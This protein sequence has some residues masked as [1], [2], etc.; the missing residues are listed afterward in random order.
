MLVGFNKPLV[1]TGAQLSIMHPHSDGIANLYGA[2]L[3]AA[4]PKEFATFEYKATK[5]GK[6]F[7]DKTPI[8]K[9]NVL[10]VMSRPLADHPLHRVSHAYPCPCVFWGGLLMNATRV[11]KLNSVGMR[12]FTSHNSMP[13][14][15]QDATGFIV[16]NSM[17]EKRY[18]ACR[19]TSGARH[20]RRHGSART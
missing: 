9:P 13:D 16:N 18:V 4:G 11:S 8:V 20:A 7:V 5:A 12:A 3:V 14:G 10:R 1:V 19:V 15:Y 2:C 6:R 17:Q